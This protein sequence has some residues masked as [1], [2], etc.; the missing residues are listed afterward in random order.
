MFV[1]AIAAVGS[2]EITPVKQDYL[3]VIHQGRLNVEGT[4]A[5]D[6]SNLMILLLIHNLAIY[7]RCYRT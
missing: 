1:Y 2:G 7:Y 6:I 4:P 5:E 3:F